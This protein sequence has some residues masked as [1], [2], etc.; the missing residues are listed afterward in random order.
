MATW[1]RVPLEVHKS[2]EYSTLYHKVHKRNLPY[3]NTIHGLIIYIRGSKLYTRLHTRTTD[4]HMYLNFNSEHAM[5]LK[6][7]V[8]YSQLPRLK[9]IHT[10]PQHLLEAQIHMYLFLWREYPH[11]TILKA[12]EQ[13]N[14]V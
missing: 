2:L 10:E 14:K 1:E 12:W 6:K 8:P 9:R 13:T 4:R 5:S 7:S 11:N 3:R